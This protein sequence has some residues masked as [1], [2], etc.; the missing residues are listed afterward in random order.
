MSQR[1]SITSVGPGRGPL[2]VS[3]KPLTD[4]AAVDVASLISAHL[5]LMD[6]G[7]ILVKQDAGEE[8][9][10]RKLRKCPAGNQKHCLLLCDGSHGCCLHACLNSVP[11]LWSGL[12]VAQP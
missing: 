7:L 12:I 1:S 9:A 3:M 8:Q 11:P 10:R 6:P 2:R 4:A 5:G